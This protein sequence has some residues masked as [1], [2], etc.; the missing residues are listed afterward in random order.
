SDPA[1]LLPTPPTNLVTSQIVLPTATEES[2][3]RFVG[4]FLRFFERNSAPGSRFSSLYAQFFASAYLG[5][6]CQLTPRLDADRPDARTLLDEFVGAMVE[7]VWPPPVVVPATAGP[8]LDVSTRLSAPRG[9][10]PFLGKYKSANLRR[11]Y[12]DEQLRTLHRYLTDPRFQS[13]DS[14]VELFPAGGAI[15]T[16]AATATA[17][18]TRDSFM[19]AVFVTAWRNPAD[20]AAHLEWSRSMFR[21]I[22]AD[23]GGVPVPNHA[24]AGAYVNYPDADLR[25]PAQNTS[26]AAWSTL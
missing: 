13:Q 26:T 21:D 4:N 2:F 5:G 1:R 14:G 12:T 22:Y 10:A 20:E 9:R 19:K 8:F 15:N 24:N 25:D 18:P 16:R 17:M 3:V 6:L 7:G 23:T 11:A